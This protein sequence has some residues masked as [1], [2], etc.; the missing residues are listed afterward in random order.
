MSEPFHDDGGVFHHADGTNIA[1]GMN[2]QRHSY[3]SY[4]SFND[5]DG[6]GWI[7][8]EVTARLSADIKAGDSR[9]APQLVSWI[10]GS[11]ASGDDEPH[12]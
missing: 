12:R 1:A 6:N 9:F 11:D 10:T 8:Q 4:A 2:A 5:P 3:A 7:L